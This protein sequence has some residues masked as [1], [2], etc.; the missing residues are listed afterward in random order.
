MKNI[1]ILLFLTLTGLNA[2]TQKISKLINDIEPKVIEWRRYFYQNPKLSN[3]EFN[4][5]AKIV[6]HLKV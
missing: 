3:R 5:V 4:T 1:F 6:E 2:Q